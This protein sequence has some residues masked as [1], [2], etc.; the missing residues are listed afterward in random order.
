MDPQNFLRTV[1]LCNIVTRHWPSTVKSSNF[2]IYFYSLCPSGYTSIMLTAMYVQCCEIWCGP[3]L[4][5]CCRTVRYEETNL[6]SSLDHIILSLMKPINMQVKLIEFHCD[7]VLK[8][9]FNYAGCRAFCTNQSP[10][11][12][13]HCLLAHTWTNAFNREKKKK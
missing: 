7:S 6:P 8:R 4:K 10:H 5:I 3:K 9:S 2:P 12:S 13:P 11:S 1:K